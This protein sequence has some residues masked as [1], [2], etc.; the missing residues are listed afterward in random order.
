MLNFEQRPDDVLFFPAQFNSICP[1]TRISTHWGIFH[2]INKYL[3]RT[4][5]TPGSG[6]TALN[7]RDT[8]HASRSSQAAEE[9]NMKHRQDAKLYQEFW[10]LSSG[11]RQVLAAFLTKC[12]LRTNA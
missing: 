6:D 3:L 2:S 7:T 9:A 5:Y 4:L 10:E 8:V 12:K 11:T 1:V